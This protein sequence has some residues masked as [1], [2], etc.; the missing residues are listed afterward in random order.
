[1]LPTIF[2]LGDSALTINFGSIIN[3]EI[4]NKVH[5]LFSLLKQEN[6]LAIKDVIPAYASLTIVYDVVQIKKLTA[7]SA[8]KYMKN[9]AE[10][11]FDNLSV[12][13]KTTSRVIEIPVCYDPSFGFDLEEMSIAKNTSYEEIIQ[14]HLSKKYRV[15]MI[16]FL[17]GFPYMGSVEERIAT[18]RKNIPRTKIPAGSVGIAGEQTGIYSLDSP[19]GWNI[20]GR[21][22]INLFNTALDQPCLLQPGDMVNFISISLEDFY[23]IKA[24]Q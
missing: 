17:P 14:L 10:N 9:M 22:P 24:Q 19:G 7:G 1:M 12:N 21:T 18:P 23:K 5:A 20:I 2:P 13:H 11:A 4:N 16:G 6:H 3:N 8:Y 15:Y